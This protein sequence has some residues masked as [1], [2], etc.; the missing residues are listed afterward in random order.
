MTSVHANHR[1]A[2]VS[3]KCLEPQWGET[4]LGEIAFTASQGGIYYRWL[5]KN[6]KALFLGSKSQMVTRQTLQSNAEPFE[7]ALSHA[8][9]SIRRFRMLRK[10][11]CEP[12]T[13]NWT[14]AVY[15]A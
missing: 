13:W 3:G 11:V 15:R 12:L 2:Q 8:I 9:E 5:L 7:Y 14:N 1:T 6:E 10:R 4:F